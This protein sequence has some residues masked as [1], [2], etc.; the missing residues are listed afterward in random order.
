MLGGLPQVVGGMSWENSREHAEIDAALRA[1][2][3]SRPPISGKLVGA[4]VEVSIRHAKV[5]LTLGFLS[6]LRACLRG[7]LRR[8]GIARPHCGD[9]EAA[10]ARSRP[11]RI[12]VGF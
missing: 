2:R 5:R 9:I 3:A 6:R 8:A 10:C 11:L 4:V 7:C 12:G 1:V